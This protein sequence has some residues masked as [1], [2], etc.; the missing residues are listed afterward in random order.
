MACPACIVALA[1]VGQLPPS[2]PPPAPAGTAA[3]L[4]FLGGAAVGF[5]LLYLVLP[6]AARS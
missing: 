2:P 5:L 1:G 4:P 3:L 6:K